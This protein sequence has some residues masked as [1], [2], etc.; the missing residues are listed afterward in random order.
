MFPTQATALA[1]GNLDAVRPNLGMTPAVLAAMEDE[2][3]SFN[4]RIANVAIIPEKVW[5]EAAT[6]AL[7]EVTTAVAHVPAGPG[8]N[9]PEVQPVARATRIFSPVETG[10]VGMLWRIC[11]RLFWTRAGNNWDNYVDFDVMLDPA[12]RPAAM[13][14]AAPT[15]VVTPAPAASKFKQSS[16]TDQ[17]DDSEF[18]APTRADIDRYNAAYFA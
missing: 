4:N 11:A 18:P 9:P 17:G 14:P 1:W 3:G 13:L 8:G 15:V 16:V 2:L 7:V 10:Q 12:S 5:R 6:A